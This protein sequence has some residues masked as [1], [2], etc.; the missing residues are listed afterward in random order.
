MTEPTS[1]PAA[2]A[3]TPATMQ[4]FS[5]TAPLP[6]GI[7][8]IE[9]SAGTGKTWTLAAL[10]TRFV[11]EQ[12][13]D[14]DA[15]LVVTFSRAAT[16]ELRERVRAQL[17]FAHLMLTH[18]ETPSDDPLIAH[19]RGANVDVRAQY[20]SRLARA[21]ATFD[22]ATI[23][24]I[25]QFC[26]YV[27]KGLGVAGDSDPYATLTEAPTDLQ[28][29]VIDDLFLAAT[30][31]KQGFAVPHSVAR[32]A[33]LTVLNNPAAIVTPQPQ[34]ATSQQQAQLVAFCQQ[35]RS[36]YERR[37]RRAGI[38]EYDDLLTELNAALHTPH[39]TAAERMRARWKVVLVDEFQ[40]TDPVQWSIF[41]TAFHGDDRS[42]ILVGDPKQAIYGFR[43][44]DI[45]TYLAA[46][47]QAHHRLT[48]PT[49]YR[50][51]GPLVSALQRFIGD[52]QLS[53]GVVA[54]SVR[55]H[56]HDQSR[57]SGLGERPIE[58]RWLAH[59]AMA[60]GEAR[61]LLYADVAR[62]TSEMLNAGATFDGRP[63]EPSD[64]AVLCHLTKDLHGIREALRTAG[65]PAVM[66]SSE[67][68]LRTEAGS[69]WLQ[70]LMALEQ[71]HRSDRVR[72]ACLT[73]L[74]GWTI[75]QL[76]SQR[77]APTDECGEL[78]HSLRATFERSGV[79]GVADALRARGLVARLLSR[80]GGDRDMTDTE[81][82]AQLLA[83][84]QVESASGIASLCAWLAAQ[85]AADA[86]VT[87]DARIMRLDS[88]AQA[89]S[90]VTI[91]ASKGLQYPIVLAPTLWERWDRR[92]TPP[93][94]IHGPHGRE[95]TFD[96]YRSTS[97]EHKEALSAELMRMAYVAMTRAQSH[98]ALWWVPTKVNTAK[99]P[100]TRLLFGQ[101]DADDISQLL[102]ER[103]GGGLD[104]P[105]V[106]VEQT[107]CAT[108]TR[109]ASIMQ[110]WSQGP[111]APFNASVIDAGAPILPYTPPVSDEPITL[112][113]FDPTH[114][115]TSWRRTSYSA[116]TAAGEALDAAR[117]Q[118]AFDGPHATE[119]SALM[120]EPDDDARAVA[121]ADDEMA[122]AMVQAE[123]AKAIPGADALSPMANAPMGATFG[124]L[125]HAALEFVDFQ[126]RDLRAE[127]VR[128]LGE[129][130]QFWP[131]ETDLNAL[132]GALVTVCHTPMGP[133]VH[134]AQL[135]D[136]ART[137]RLPEM[138]FEIPLAGGEQPTGE[139]VLR[140]FVPFL[141][142][143][144][145]DDPLRRYA[146]VLMTS[147][148]GEQPLRGYLTGSID[149]TFRHDG[150]YYVVDY[151][152]NWLGDFDEP[153]TLAGY[154]PS[155]LVEAMNHSSY[156]LQAIL[157]SVV[158]HRYLRW[159]LPSY[160]P[161]KHLGG[162]MYL[163]VRGMAGPETPR[164]GDAP[165]GVF[166]WAPPATLVTQLSD[167]LAGLGSLSAGTKEENA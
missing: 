50:S 85:T 96:A 97:D 151:K 12:G 78:I 60:I 160:D 27:L 32:D 132:A 118:Q 105:L 162:V 155:A 80:V 144:P 122:G 111:H 106:T 139:P 147:A 91:H 77:D 58:M 28:Q 100:L 37:K 71:P 92:I 141:K 88:D 143:L 119:S 104:G 34:E 67:S 135:T 63:I 157:Y 39:S 90:L 15:L 121:H 145:E 2:L 7:T 87:P 152:T 48:L 123:A 47:A 130:V 19:L 161:E 3:T 17:E 108:P 53:D 68:V 6:T 124:S 98:L 66:A 41:H 131:V 14:V 18:P 56:R 8:M 75:E 22:S 24:T 134:E 35:V 16:Q 42:L 94:V 149:L 129:Q 29:Q 31:R 163:Y 25:H 116:L 10:V 36:E 64:I 159:R 26:H 5:I 52:V 4:P 101:R 13:L 51:D 113:P 138:E 79:A 9:A 73:P 167:V 136:I 82:C 112:R 164:Q 158:L 81:H 107:S 70:L 76:E 65:I 55:A 54:S 110:A 43:G 1:T 40:D 133:L 21:M 156:P 89:V 72:A 140:D 115:D 30:L 23:A 95:V 61:P 127:F 128:V 44:G 99:S 62:R 93:Q 153:L 86:R 38:L 83:T 150:R 117:T 102:A 142:G 74:I 45:H 154:A 57:L 125:V 33:A 165:F 69:W 49:N 109:A 84:R 46:R 126:A 137:D 148:L 166:S 59:P 114:V 146:D 103:A 11:A 120:S 20:V